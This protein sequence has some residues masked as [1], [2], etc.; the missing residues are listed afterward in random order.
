MNY[1]IFF[2]FQKFRDEVKRN[3][4]KIQEIIYFLQNQRVE[5]QKILHVPLQHRDEKEFDAEMRQYK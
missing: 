2:F 1:S 3:R 4:T 5:L